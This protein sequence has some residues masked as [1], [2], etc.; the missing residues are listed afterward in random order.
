MGTSRP[1]EVS[2]VNRHQGKKSAVRL[3]GLLLPTHL[4]GTPLV[5]TPGTGA[6][7]INLQILLRV[8]PRLGKLSTGSWS[9]VKSC[10]A[11]WGSTIK[12]GHSPGLFPARL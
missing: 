6:C 7:A 9:A 8:V 2:L 5:Q 12:G 11:S 3:G 10:P 4:R 1:G